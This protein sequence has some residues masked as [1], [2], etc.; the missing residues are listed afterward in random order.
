MMFVAFE[1]EGFAKVERL[2]PCPELDLHRPT[3]A[4]IWLTSACAF[5]RLVSRRCQPSRIKPSGQGFLPLSRNFL[6]RSARPATRPY[7]LPCSPTLTSRS[8]MSPRKPPQCACAGFRDSATPDGSDG[9]DG[10]LGH[11]RP[12]VKPFDM[13]SLPTRSP[14][15]AS[16]LR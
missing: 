3:I 14:L 9:S 5:F 12:A 10:R 1:I 15:L 11:E 7:F 8:M 13:P 6:R 4:A 16:N 2:L